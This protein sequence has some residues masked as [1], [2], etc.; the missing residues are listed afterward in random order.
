ML[1]IL[2][3]LYGRICDFKWWDINLRIGMNFF[4]LKKILCSTAVRHFLCKPLKKGERVTVFVGRGRPFLNILKVSKL[5]TLCSVMFSNCTFLSWNLYLAQSFCYLIFCKV[6]SLK[7]H[8]LNMHQKR[9][10][11]LLYFTYQPFQRDSRD[12]WR[13]IQL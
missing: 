6:H 3:H 5:C 10:L 13:K 12:S 8:K 1:V 11:W 2:K 7:F 4:Y 9:A